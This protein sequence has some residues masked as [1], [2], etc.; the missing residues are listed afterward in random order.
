MFNYKDCRFRV[1][2]YKIGTARVVAWKQF[3]ITHSF[4]L[5]NSFYGYE[6]GEKDHK[7][8]SSDDYKDMGLKFIMA[9]YDMHFMWKDIRKELAVT[10]GWLKPRTLNEMTGVP[11]A[12]KIAEEQ[13][14]LQKEARK[15]EAIAKYELFLQTFYKQKS[16]K[17]KE[18]KN[19]E[20]EDESPQKGKVTNIKAKVFSEDYGSETVDIKDDKEQMYKM[21]QGLVKIQ[22]LVRGW[23]GR[24]RIK[25]ILQSKD[26][27]LIVAQLKQ[28]NK[29]NR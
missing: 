9:I 25:K 14:M 7:I 18:T 5:E 23:L 27:K 22:A 26:K 29:M 1:E 13:A 15:K 11:A 12:Q 6:M 2:P 21:H 24:K 3:Q 8:Y 16:L 17:K 28:Q 20:S 10:H 19:G 4:T